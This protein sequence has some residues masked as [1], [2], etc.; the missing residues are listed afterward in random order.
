MVLQLRIGAL[1]LL[2]LVDKAVAVC[3]RLKYLLGCLP[4]LARRL[5]P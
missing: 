2:V 3:R 5:D 1:C 4:R